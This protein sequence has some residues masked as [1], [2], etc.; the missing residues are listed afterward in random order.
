MFMA[1][2][3]C[4]TRLYYGIMCL[5]IGVVLNNFMHLQPKPTQMLKLITTVV[6]GHIAIIIKQNT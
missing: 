6:S 2:W 1:I 5:K 3:K 4:K